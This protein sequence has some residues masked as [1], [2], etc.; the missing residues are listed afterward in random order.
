VNAHVQQLFCIESTN[1]LWRYQISDSTWTWISGGNTR[2]RLGIYGEKGKASLMNIPGV[3]E[4]ANIWYEST[5]EEIW[6]FGGT[7]YSD[8][9]S[10]V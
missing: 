7:G 2:Y 1:D 9:F 5:R 6:L 10:G 3:R 4:D 8:A